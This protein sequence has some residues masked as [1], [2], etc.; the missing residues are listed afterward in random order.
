MDDDAVCT[1]CGTWPVYV[2]PSGRVGKLCAICFMERLDELLSRIPK[3]W[4]RPW[5]GPP[6]HHRKRGHMPQLWRILRRVS[7]GMTTRAD[8][9]WLLW[10]IITLRSRLDR[11][12][13]EL[14][15]MRENVGA[16]K[17]ECHYWKHQFGEW[18]RELEEARADLAATRDDLNTAR[19]DFQAAVKECCRLRNEHNPNPWGRAMREADNAEPL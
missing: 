7:R 17:R 19:D 15:G 16:L 9:D 1:I 14:K 12:E 11:A 4:G 6:Q 3:P 8:A 13:G 18:D 10:E 2:S 5:Q